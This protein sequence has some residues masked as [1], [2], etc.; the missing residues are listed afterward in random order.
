MGPIESSLLGD[1]NQTPILHQIRN[2]TSPAGFQIWCRVF[3]FGAKPCIGARPNFAASCAILTLVPSGY[4][5][6]HNVSNVVHFG[7]WKMDRQK[8]ATLDLTKSRPFC[9]SQQDVECIL[10]NRFSNGIRWHL[11]SR[12]QARQTQTFFVNLQWTQ[13]FEVISNLHFA[14][15]YLYNASS[16][17]LYTVEPKDLNP[18]P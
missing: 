10:C 5:Y 18:I 6:F 14:V 12:Q 8:I 4:S 15:N 1:G 16:V 13:R 9:F 17:T 11:S 3:F 7:L 2:S